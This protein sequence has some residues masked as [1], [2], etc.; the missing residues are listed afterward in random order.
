MYI[1]PLA[2]PTLTQTFCLEDTVLDFNGV[3]NLL[4]LAGPILAQN[5]ATDF[6]PIRQNSKTPIGNSCLGHAI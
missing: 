4:S 2:G 3:A 1:F 6:T 5:L